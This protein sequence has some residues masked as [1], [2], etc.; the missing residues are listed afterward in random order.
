MQDKQVGSMEVP[1]ASIF[2]TRTQDTFRNLVEPQQGMAVLAAKGD[3]HHIKKVVKMLVFNKLRIP[4]KHLSL[5][6]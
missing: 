4:T 1:P 3:L 2:A 6:F 5:V